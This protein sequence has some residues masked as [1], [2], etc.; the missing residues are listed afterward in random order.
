M[1]DTSLSSL[2]SSTQSQTRSG[3]F[4]ALEAHHDDRD[5]HPSRGSLSSVSSL[6]SADAHAVA[7]VAPVNATAAD[8]CTM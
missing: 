3:I 8:Y 7:D 2:S 6:G 4:C 1:V 5:G